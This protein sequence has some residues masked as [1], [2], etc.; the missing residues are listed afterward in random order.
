MDSGTICPSIIHS[1]GH[2]RGPAGSQQ[3][4]PPAYTPQQ[5]VSAAQSEL[6]RSGLGSGE[7]DHLYSTVCKPKAGEQAPPGNSTMVGSG[8]SELDRLLQELNTAQFNITDEILAQFPPRKSGRGPGR[9]EGS[10]PGL[11]PHRR[12]DRPEAGCGGSGGGGDNEGDGEW[13]ARLHWSFDPAG[14]I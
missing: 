3:P 13:A 5:T 6:N 14:A 2:R 10:G 9:D 8:L 7:K 4:P 1:D 12:G 11:R